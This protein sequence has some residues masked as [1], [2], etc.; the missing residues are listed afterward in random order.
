MTRPADS[1]GEN[2]ESHPGRIWVLTDGK[3]GDDV[4]C[5]AVASGLSP[6]FEKRV[7][8][9][10]WLWAMLA[11]YGPVDPR[12][13]PGREEGPLAG[14]FPDAAIVSGRRAIPHARALKKASGGK[15]RIVILKDPRFGRGVADALWAPAHDRLDGANAFSTLTSPHALGARVLSPPAPVPAI[16]ALPKPFLGVVLGGVT[17]GG[18]ADY[19]AEAARDLAA[20]LSQA[21]RDYAA[22]AV[23]PS[24]RTPPAFLDVLKASLDHPKLFIWNGEGDNP[25]PDILAQAA[26]LVVAGDSHNMTSEALA[27]RAAVY[28]WKPK[29]LAAKMGWFIGELIARGEAK[30][31]ESAAPV[32][33]RI[34]LDAT[35]EI[36]AEIR[37][38]LE[39]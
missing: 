27:S 26:A 9:P 21:G 33:G 16:A 3:I 10:R 18:G 1:Q 34:P 28:I 30:L 25:Y 17:A 39:L 6:S 8:A 14:P 2:G 35:P 31:F 4:Q 19:S 36:I 22:V 23:T 38:R 29:G 12:E 15:T 5:L 24:R 11:P 13:A 32:F 20:R 37:K 7:V